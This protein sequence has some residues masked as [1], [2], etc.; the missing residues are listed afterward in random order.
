MAGEP[1]ELR[2]YKYRVNNMET[3]G[4]LTPKMAERLGAVGVDDTLPDDD[5]GGYTQNR[6]QAMLGTTDMASG[7]KGDKA[8]RPWRDQQ[9]GLDGK[10][11]TASMRARTGDSDAAAAEESPETKARAAKNKS[12]D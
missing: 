10:G 6:T 9:M 5:N 8:T 12:R 7:V 4:M 3:T 11:R 1:N 2:E